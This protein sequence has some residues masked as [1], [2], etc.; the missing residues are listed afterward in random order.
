MSAYEIDD[1]G[2]LAPRPRSLAPIL[3]GGLLV[4]LAAAMQWPISQWLRGFLSHRPRI[5]GKGNWLLDRGVPIEVIRES[6]LGRGKTTV[7]AA[8]GAPRTAAIG[9]GQFSDAAAFWYADTWYYPV[10]SKSKTAMA[11]RFDRGIARE[12]DFFEAPTLD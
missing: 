7:A 11:V 3:V 8:F 9:R 5:A 12:V 4:A 6:V 1:E 2:A 10:D